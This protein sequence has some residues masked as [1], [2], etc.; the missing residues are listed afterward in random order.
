MMLTTM[1]TIASHHSDLLLTAVYSLWIAVAWISEFVTPLRSLTLAG[2]TQSFSSPS[3]PTNYDRISTR[4]VMLMIIDFQVPKQWF[5]HFYVA[6]ILSCCLTILNARH[7]YH[8]CLL[9]VLL[10]VSR[11]SY[12]CLYVHAWT[13]ASRMHLCVY[14]VGLTHYLLLPFNWTIQEE[15]ASPLL[16]LCGCCLCLCAQYEQHMHH[17]LLASQRVDSWKKGS[18]HTYG[19]IL[20]QGRWFHWIGSPQYLAEILIY[21]GFWMQLQNRSGMLLLAWVASN[22]TLCALRTHAW[23]QKNFKQYKKE[24]RKAIVPFVF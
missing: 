9:T 15:P 13:P 2:K 20:P 23:Y 12:E 16:S 1:L 18:K 22:Q 21:I 7:F 4:S 17:A 8:M 6:G 19:Y 10:Q 24:K 5:L 11:R 14:L 3:S